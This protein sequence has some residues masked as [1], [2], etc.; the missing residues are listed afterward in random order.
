MTFDPVTGEWTHSQA[1]DSS[2]GGALYDPKYDPAFGD[3]MQG[4]DIGA[5]MAGQQLPSLPATISGAGIGGIVNDWAGKLGI[6]PWL[7]IA[8]GAAA[9]VYTLKS[10]GV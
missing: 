4:S 7:L 6:P 1:P 10:A 5:I 2:S 3:F 9:A 8:M